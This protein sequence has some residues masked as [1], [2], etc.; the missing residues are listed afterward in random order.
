MQDVID[1]EF[2]ETTV[3]SVMHRFTFIERFDRVAVLRQGNIVE[4]D[5]P[6]MLLGRESTFR[7]L[8]RAHHE[9]AVNVKR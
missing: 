7:A 2:K 9:R 6:Q 3:I 8:Y 5:K 1:A 4:C